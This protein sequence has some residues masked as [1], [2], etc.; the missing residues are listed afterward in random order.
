MFPFVFGSESQNPSEL[1]TAMSV[2]D[3]PECLWASYIIYSS[4]GLVIKSCKGAPREKE[5]VQKCVYEKGYIYDLEH[6]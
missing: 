5:F 1:C 2:T 3:V 6:Q 4:S